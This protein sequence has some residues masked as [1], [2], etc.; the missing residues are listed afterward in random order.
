MVVKI[1]GKRR[2]LWR[3]VDDE[4]EVLD[5]LLKKRRNEGAALK[6]PRR[7]L[8]NTRLHPETII[9]DGLA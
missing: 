7:L 8:K 3:A 6:L 5:V 2:W 9:T 4:G 1:G